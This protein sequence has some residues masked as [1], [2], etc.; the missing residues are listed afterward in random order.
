MLNAG[1]QPLEIRAAAFLG[2]TKP[3]HIGDVGLNQQILGEER[4]QAAQQWAEQRGVGRVPINVDARGMMGRQPAR[5]VVG[6][7]G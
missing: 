2:C 4:M 1:D 5:D 3:V 6:E 7:D